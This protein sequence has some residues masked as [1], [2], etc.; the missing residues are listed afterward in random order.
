MRP[1]IRQ[2][3]HIRPV[4]LV[5]RGLCCTGILFLCL[6]SGCGLTTPTGENHP[7]ELSVIEQ[8]SRYAEFSG[9]PLTFLVTLPETVTV[10]AIN[11]HTWANYRAGRHPDA[12]VTQM[13]YT[14]HWSSYPALQDTVRGVYTHYDSI[15]VTANGKKSNP[16]IV[17]V[18]NIAP[19]IISV[20][21]GDSLY[22]TT[23]HDTLVYTVPAPVQTTQLSV[24]A[25]DNEQSSSLKYRFFHNGYDY[26]ESG[27]T[28]TIEKNDILLPDTVWCE[29]A[30]NNGGKDTKI[31]RLVSGVPNKAP[32]ISAVRVNDTS[33]D[34][35]AGIS[36]YRDST[37]DTVRFVVTADDSDAAAAQ[38]T[39]HW[40][41]SGNAGH[42]YTASAD[43][44]ASV[45]YVCTSGV[46][47]TTTRLLD[48]VTVWVQ[49]RRGGTSGQVRIAVG[50]GT[51][52]RAPALDS[53]HVGDTTLTETS[54]AYRHHLRPADSLRIAIAGGVDTTARL[55]RMNWR[56]TRP[57]Y[58]TIVDSTADTC[59]YV[60]TAA[61][62]LF[63]DTVVA[64][65]SD[66]VFS[67]DTAVTRR[68]SVIVV[69]NHAPHIDS[70]FIFAST[71]A[72]IGGPVSSADTLEFSSSPGDTVTSVAHASQTDTLD[73]LYYAW[74][75]RRSPEGDSLL[76]STDSLVYL[77]AESTRVR[78]YIGDSMQKA[79]SLDILFTHTP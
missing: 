21:I 33:L 37:L 41:V 23:Q 72:T 58:A 61:E 3:R 62:S 34:A 67:A 31:V 76:A 16:V 68:C 8:G 51:V 42:L 71:Q 49:D 77:P 14:L 24:S 30:D 52:I 26:T 47:S 48:T 10:S 75:L 53:V 60:V 29:V 54:P 4:S 6:H 12:R 45:A 55:R 19:R 15:W 35:A 74:Y 1:L 43:T 56:H 69:P 7:I 63:I 5:L 50:A 27:N 20:T 64:V 36:L 13:S 65:I 66:S 57:A 18:L 28:F 9:E 2:Y 70:I 44:G 39:Y 46:C 32:Y 78:L 73:S 17:S 40:R 38:L 22:S 25:T 59:V 79:D 11:F